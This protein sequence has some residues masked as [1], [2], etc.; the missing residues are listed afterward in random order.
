MRHFIKIIWTYC[1]T[2]SFLR[3][4]EKHFFAKNCDEMILSPD[5]TETLDPFSLYAVL[6]V[7]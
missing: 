1:N 7:M 5:V 2:H 4:E 6:A 3:I